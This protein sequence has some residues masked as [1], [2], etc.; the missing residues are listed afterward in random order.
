M[1][2][3]IALIDPDVGGSDPTGF[4]L[5]Y[6]VFDFLG[7]NAAFAA[8]FPEGDAVDAVVADPEGVVVGVGEGVV[9][10]AHAGE[11]AARG[12]DEGEE[13]GAAKGGGEMVAGDLGVV[14]DEGGM[15]VGLG[16]DLEAG[17]GF[18]VGGEEKLATDEHRCTQM[19]RDRIRL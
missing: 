6:V 13:V 7:E 19:K 9:G 14:P 15:V 5:I 16:E 4:A 8:V 12:A 10:V 18:G 17:D 3:V 1:F 11:A 2:V